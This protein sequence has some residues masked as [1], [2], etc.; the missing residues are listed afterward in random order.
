MSTSV[1]RPVASREGKRSPGPSRLHA[2]RLMEFVGLFSVWEGWRREDCDG[3]L[4]K[5]LQYSQYQLFY[6]MEGDIMFLKRT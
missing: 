5:A 6:N 4:Y 3:V 1:R 2:G